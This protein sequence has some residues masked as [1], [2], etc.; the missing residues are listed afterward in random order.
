MSYDE[1]SLYYDAIYMAMKDYPRRPSDF[2]ICLSTTRNGRSVSCS[3][4]RAGPVFTTDIARSS[5]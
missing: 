1:P 2:A 3:T 5:R 4:W